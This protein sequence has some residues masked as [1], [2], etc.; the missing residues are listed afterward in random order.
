LLPALDK[1]HKK[2]EKAIKII[3]VKCD[4]FLQ[5]GRILDNFKYT[6]IALL[7]QICYI[8]NKEGYK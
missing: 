3:F 1:G 4:C 8:I 7:R 5:K 2:E 6:E